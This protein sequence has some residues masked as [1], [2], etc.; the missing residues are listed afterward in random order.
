MT[1]DGGPEAL[2][3]EFE[4]ARQDLVAATAAVR[5]KDTPAARRELADRRA[6]IDAILD[7]WNAGHPVPRR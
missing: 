4:S 5:R 6:R 1:T 2:L 3:A 7:S